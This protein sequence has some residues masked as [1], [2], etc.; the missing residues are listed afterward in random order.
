MNWLTQYLIDK[1]IKE[2]PEKVI[3][4]LFTIRRYCVLMLVL[5][6][7]DIRV[8]DLIRSY[9]LGVRLLILLI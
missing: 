4:M 8:L 6:L 2:N 9:S 1:A 5:L 3:K 7:K